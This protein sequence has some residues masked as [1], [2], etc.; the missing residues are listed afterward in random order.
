MTSQ[1]RALGD[2]L[3]ACLRSD[4]EAALRTLTLLGPGVHSLAAAA[5]YH[6]ILPTVER[7]LREAPLPAP[8]RQQ[9]A[10]RAQD[11]RAQALRA[12]HAAVEVSTLLTELAIPHAVV[13]GPM[14]AEPLGQPDRAN[15]DLDLLV[16]PSAVEP[17]LQ[18][19]RAAGAW[20]LDDYRWPRADGVG[21]LPLGWPPGVVLDLHWSLVHHADVR[22]RFHLP[23]EQLIDRGRDVRVLEQPIPTLDELDTLVHVATHAAISGGHRLVWLAD[24]DAAIRR[25]DGVQ[26]GGWDGLVQRARRAGTDLVL[27][28][29]LDRTRRALGTPLSAE[30]LASLSARGRLWRG[31]AGSF[32][33]LRPVSRSYHRSFR[34]Q[35]LVRATGPT[36]GVS[37]RVLRQLMAVEAVSRRDV[38]SAIPADSRA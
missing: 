9:L 2:L 3:V 29:M 25:L 15:G 4:A 31:L 26:H 28:L 19:L 14:L 38:V 30:L 23:P 37:L 10:E 35:L 34:G 24:L 18:A 11:Q 33:A 17:A 36:T 20:H 6:G 27:A 12:S 5:D 22:A 32:D 13:K 8:V 7:A 21:E 16:P 1:R